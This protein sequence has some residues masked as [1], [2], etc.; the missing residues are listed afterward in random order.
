M[1]SSAPGG[2]L[3]P[4]STAPT[5]QPALSV[6]A[7]PLSAQE[8]ISRCK[9]PFFKVELASV[10]EKL[11]ITTRDESILKD[12]ED[13]NGTKP[14]FQ[15]VMLKVQELQQRC[16]DH[17]QQLKYQ[18]VTHELALQRLHSRYIELVTQ[19]LEELVQLQS[20]G[21]Q[22]PGQAQGST[23]P[24]SSSL[25][26]HANPQYGAGLMPG[27][28]SGVSG[29][30]SG[31]SHYAVH[32]TPAYPAGTASVAPPVYG[33][34]QPTPYNQCTH[35]HK[36]Q[37][38]HHVPYHTPAG[39]MHAYNSGQHTPCAAPHHYQQH[40]QPEMHHPYPMHGTPRGARYWF[41]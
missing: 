39:H 4:G 5:Q 38:A 18:L 26:Q 9:L 35:A 36:Y 14:L 25:Q 20:H 15:K 1:A 40:V 23:P 27:E 17:E 28:L 3:E 13:P 22:T 24:P 6:T 30:I 33:G 8:L 32:H 21:Q 16:Q 31:A 10:L 34:C 7:V 37:S 19:Y 11:G 2:S 41:Y 12:W 29:G